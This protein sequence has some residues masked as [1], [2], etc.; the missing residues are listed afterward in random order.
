MVE[1]N[2]DLED[3]YFQ[4]VTDLTSKDWYINMHF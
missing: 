2:D 4:N 3:P 1:G